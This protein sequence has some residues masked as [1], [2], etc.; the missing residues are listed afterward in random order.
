MNLVVQCE[1]NVDRAQLPGGPQI[2]DQLYW[3]EV[4]DD[5][6]GTTIN[7]SPED[8]GVP[9]G[10]PVFCIHTFARAAWIVIAEEPDIV[11]GPRRFLRGNETHRVVA[12]PR[13]RIAF[14]LA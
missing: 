14:E 8:D 2:S 4:F 11:N 5:D 3:S 13:A 12:P 10:S 7:A 9:L 6:S 1:S